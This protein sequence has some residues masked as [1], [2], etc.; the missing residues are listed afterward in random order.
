V[1]LSRSYVVTLALLGLSCRHATEASVA[2]LVPSVEASR[3]SGGCVASLDEI[4][5]AFQAFPADLVKDGTTCEMFQR[6]EQRTCPSVYVAIANGG[7]YGGS[8]RYFDGDRKLLG[9]WVRSDT[10]QYCNRTSFD[11]VYGTRPTCP[12]AEIVT[13]LCRR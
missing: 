8:T 9:V 6:V 4:R 3:S 13:D 7:G 12:T 2:P 1:T 11:I 5:D 10:N